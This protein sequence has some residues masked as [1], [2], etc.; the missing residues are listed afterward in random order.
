MV[1]IVQGSVSV[2]MRDCVALLLECVHVPSSGVGLTAILVSVKVVCDV[3]RALFVPGSC[4]D[5]VKN[6]DESNVDCGGT[7]CPPCPTEVSIYI[8]YRETLFDSH[9][10]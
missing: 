5:G 10:L 2:R 8:Q 7:L 9:D 4:G 1:K 3:K 6:N